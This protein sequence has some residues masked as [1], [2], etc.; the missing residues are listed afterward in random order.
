MRLLVQSA[1]MRRRSDDELVFL[2]GHR[3]TYLRTLR[4]TVSSAGHGPAPWWYVMSFAVVLVVVGGATRNLGVLTVGA[5]LGGLFILF[6]FVVAAI[7]YVRH[8]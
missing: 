4:D 1:A 2:G 3:H 8:K 7:E 6:W 5:V